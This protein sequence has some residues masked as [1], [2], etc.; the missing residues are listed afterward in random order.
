MNKIYAVV[1]YPKTFE[2]AN[3][4]QFNIYTKQ[5]SNLAIMQAYYEEQKARHSDC[6][7]V[8]VSRETAKQMQTIWR[9]HFTGAKVISHKRRRLTAW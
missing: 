3:V 7:V 1:R 8:L 4:R 2:G 9:N 6:N 5:T